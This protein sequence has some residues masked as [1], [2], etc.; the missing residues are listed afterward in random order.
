MLQIKIFGYEYKQKQISLSAV[1]HKNIPKNQVIRNE[2]FDMEENGLSA[3]N[4]LKTAN[5]HSWSRELGC[6][7]RNVS[8]TASRKKFV[9]VFIKQKT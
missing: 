4:N 6:A 8:Q 3:K 2:T 7:G 9:S 1:S 5:N